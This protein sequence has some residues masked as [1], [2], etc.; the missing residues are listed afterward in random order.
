M[1]DKEEIKWWVFRTAVSPV[2]WILILL[3][4]GLGWVGKMDLEDAIQADR[5]YCDMV[6]KYQASNGVIGWPD[7][8]SRYKEDCPKKDVLS[9]RL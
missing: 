3:V 1:F 4:L 8:E 9:R 2:F 7:Y 5:H 6:Q